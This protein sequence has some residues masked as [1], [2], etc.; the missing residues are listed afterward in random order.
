MRIPS[1]T[2]LTQTGVE[3]IIAFYLSETCENLTNWDIE[4]LALNLIQACKITT[5]REWMHPDDEKDSFK[6][7][8]VTE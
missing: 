5:R 1:N 3:N 2:E 8:E 6:Q 4:H 7:T